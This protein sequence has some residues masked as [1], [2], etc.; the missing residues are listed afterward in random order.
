MREEE[1]A[2]SLS[3]SRTPVREAMGRLKERGLLQAAPGRG[4]AVTVLSTQQVVELYAVRQELEGSV[5]RFASQHATPVEIENL[6]RRNELFG[7]AENPRLAAQLNRQFHARLYDAARNQYLRQAVEVI[8]ETIALLP[9]TTFS[10]TDRTAS[11]FE[12]HVKIIEAIRNRDPIAAERAA[13]GHIG[14]ALQIRLLIV[15]DTW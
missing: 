1:V 11:A 10:H 13:E 15:A 6:E 7:K 4:L 3:V 14:A 12:E 2:T 8:H 9:T 5:A